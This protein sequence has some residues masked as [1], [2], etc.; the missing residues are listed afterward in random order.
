MRTGYL[1]SVSLKPF[2]PVI[3]ISALCN[4]ARFLFEHFA[5]CAVE[6]FMTH[7]P[8]KREAKEAIL[9]QLKKWR[10]EGNDHISF[11][12]L[13]IHPNLDDEVTFGQLIDALG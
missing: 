13:T 6:S 5:R 2:P 7:T 11:G 3:A 9:L 12:A 4:W 8:S 10:E 1:A